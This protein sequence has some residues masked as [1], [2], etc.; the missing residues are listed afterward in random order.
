MTTQQDF[1]NTGTVFAGADLTAQSGGRLSNAGGQAGG[2]TVQLTAGRDLDNTNGK[3][4][5]SADALTVTARSV[6]NTAGTLQAKQAVALVTDG[7]DNQQGTILSEAGT[8]SLTSADNTPGMVNNAGGQM[9][10]GKAA[11]LVFSGLDNSGGSLAAF[12]GDLTLN[13]TG[14]SGVMNTAGTIKASGALTLTTDHYTA[15]DAQ[16][17]LTAAGS[18]TMTVAH[19]VQ[20]SGTLASGGD[21]ILQAATLENDQTGVVGSEAG[22]LSLTLNGSDGLNNAGTLQS[23][24]AGQTLSVTTAVLENVATGRIFSNGAQTLTVQ[25]TLTNAG[26]IT[27]FGDNAL[28]VDVGSIINSHQFQTGGSL[29]FKVKDVLKNTGLIYGLDGGS[30]TASTVAN[31]N[32]QIGEKGAKGQLLSVSADQ[33]DNSNGGKLVSQNGALALSAQTVAND[34]GQIESGSTLSILTGSLSNQSGKILSD[35]GNVTL[36]ANAA[37]AG[38]SG[39][40]N[41]SGVI[42]AANDLTLYAATLTNTNGKILAQTGNLILQG[43][44]KDGM[45]QS[46]ADQNGQLGAGQD[47]TLRTGS[48][49]GA[50]SLSAGQDLTFASSNG[51]TDPFLFSAGRDVTLS[52]GG[53]YSIGTGSG[54]I[55]Q[56]N[57]TVTAASVTNAG[58]LMATSGNLTVQTTGNITNTGL[59]DGAFGLT[60]ALDGDLSNTQGALLADAGNIFIGGRSGTYAGAV[61][62]HSGEIMAGSAS[63]DVTI[64]AA[65]LTNDIL[66]GVTEGKDANGN[67]ISVV[68][69]TQTYSQGL[70]GPLPK[71]SNLLSDAAQYYYGQ[72]VVEVFAPA[73]LLTADGQPASGSFLAA[74]YGGGESSRVVVTGTGTQMTVN[75]AP[76]L[77]AA[78]QD[79]TVDLT[80]ALANTGSHIAAGRNMTL[81]GT[82][83]DN[84]G[85]STDV[86]YTFSCYNGNSCRYFTPPA[87]EA[88]PN[89]WPDMG[90]DVGKRGGWPWPSHIW[91]S[92]EYQVQAGTLV[93]GNTL[94]ATFSGAVNNTNSVSHATAVQI[95]DA[96]AYTGSVP[97]GVTAGGNTITPS[98]V[99]S[100]VLP[101]VSGQFADVSVAAG[102]A[103]GGA[104]S[105]SGSGLYGTSGST[106]T[107]SARAASSATASLPSYGGIVSPQGHES[108]AMAA[109]SLTLPGF[110]GT[111]DPTA[112]QVIASVPAG[113]ALYVPNPAPDAHV[114]IETNPAYTSLTAFHGSE[115]LLDRLG[116]QPQDYTFLGDST[117]EQQYVQQQIVSA[118]GQTYLGGTYN[119]ASSQ[120]EA[121]LGNAANESS[122]LGLTLGQGLSAAQQSALTSDIVWYV[123]EEVN[124]IA[125]LVPKLYLT[126]GHEAL[127]GASISA[128]NVSITGGTITNSGSITAQDSLSLTTTSGDLTNTGSLSGG[129]VSLTAQDGS[130]LNSD[131]LTTYLVGG[132]STQQLASVGTITAT[133]AARADSTGRRNTLIL[134]V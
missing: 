117:F 51:I 78:G 23:A 83:L 30:I 87:S 60:L 99:G 126:P 119:T 98:A 55:A 109:Q 74:L 7:L 110:S 44:A 16:S 102:A 101:G 76:A 14:S 116:D 108:G 39:V 111:T 21:L 112:S 67:P 71:P 114:L 20:N 26:E 52:L 33:I 115:Y 31:A 120:M 57:A 130:I 61:S 62:N 4:V 91:G 84:T 6:T 3:V 104:A 11:S 92:S 5:A 125:V 106:A 81:S 19:D 35:S 15:E 43:D 66:G 94:T 127:T 63:G 32:G 28:T 95:A 48:L 70:T 58:A 131:T 29:T 18:V 50:T 45:L 90:W 13:G 12:G 86:T 8:L 103:T 128:K 64:H 2:S 96:I 24:G 75:G 121:L 118:T 80:G 73:D 41:K 25:G 36:A 37:G 42:Q 56:R 77:L 129:T 72:K 38:A 40:D 53:A 93:T 47:L 34:N 9:E 65:S 132:G 124:G 107:E 123:N 17:S 100:S 113:T 59:L 85:Y 1:A 49:T 79:L 105:V 10:A 134:E 133:G 68:Y 46:V 97:G 69:Y 54:V 22:K 89:P 88:Q 82:T 122:Q 27:A